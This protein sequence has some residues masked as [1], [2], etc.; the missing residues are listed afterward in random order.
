MQIN[1]RYRISAQLA[2]IAAVLMSPVAR[3]DEVSLEGL[4]DVE[5]LSLEELLDVEVSIASKTRERASEA[6]SS[7]T[8]FS[9]QTLRRM[10]VSTVEDLLNFVPGFNVTRDTFQ[11]E[12][13]RISVRGVHS[14]FSTGVLFLIDGQPINDMFYGTVSIFN[15]RIP[16][17][18]LQQVE[19][20]RGPAS[21]L[22]GANA[23]AAVVNM[24]TLECGNRAEVEFGDIGRM[25]GSITSCAKVGEDWRVKFFG[26]AY[27]DE[28]YAFSKV[29]DAF[30]RV[31]DIRDP[32]EGTEISA[33][34]SYKDFS[35]SVRNMTRGSGASMGYGAIG[36]SN[37]GNW[38]QTSAELRY[39]S[40][41][42]D[43]TLS[44]DVSLSAIDEFHD[45][46][47]VLVPGGVELAPGFVLQQTYIGGPVGE[48]ISV[49]GRADAT[50]QA[51]EG[52][53]LTA[54]AE[55]RYVFLGRV[56]NVHTHH[57][58]TLEYLGGEPK[59][60]TG[61]LNWV[62]EGAD[63]HF[64]GAYIRD[65]QRLFDSLT[66]HGGLRVD[67]YTDFGVA[68]SPHLAVLYELPIDAQLRA[69]YGRA[70]RAPNF[71]EL[72]Q[73]N[74]PAVVG[75]ASLKAETIDTLELA[76][77][78]QFAEVAS[79]TVTLFHNFGTNLLALG[80]PEPSGARPYENSGSLQT[81]GVELEL[82]VT[83]FKDLFV[84]GTYTHLFDATSE[85]LLAVVEQPSDMASL[86]VN[87]AIGDFN[88]NMNGFVRS[89]APLLPSQGPYGVMNARLQYALND[90]M[91]L[92]A[93]VENITDTV[94][95]GFSEYV[96][97]TGVPARGRT[98]YVG[99]A[100]EAPQPN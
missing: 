54:G 37:R 1:R 49:G 55:Y 50:W 97:L 19:V 21:S 46:T 99:F 7:V 38:R 25:K 69:T 67:Y 39:G 22:Y 6:P 63:R 8:V 74:N 59:H 40:K 48:T 47:S 29:A 13:S 100:Y 93:S 78:Q 75:N 15:R 14:A 24:V 73:K 53:Q 90:S 84:T 9:Q 44:L 41:F 80:A 33:E 61:D 81:Q 52:N 4:Q 23:F 27:R 72:Y 70:F 36:V 65:R 42:L 57:P 30:G 86:A 2:A 88:V 98:F 32:V 60:F 68:L 12:M 20:I 85:G 35:I 31:E 16:L 43:D 66:L 76:Y 51:F 56:E 3:G 95:Q 87:Y 71:A 62:V 64:A 11:A 45:P 79:S 28:G 92:S 83:P 94:Y 77:R 5:E 96:P 10:G 82:N 91:K 89:G 34:V 58:Q 17:D 26:Y 18:N